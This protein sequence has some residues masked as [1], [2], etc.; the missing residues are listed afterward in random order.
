MV[1]QR[2]SLRAQ[3]VVQRPSTRNVM[4][5]DWRHLQEPFFARSRPT[6]GSSVV[7]VAHNRW[8]LDRCEYYPLLPLSDPTVRV[9]LYSPGKATFEWLSCLLFAETTWPL[10]TFASGVNWCSQN[11]HT[12]F[13]AAFGCHQRGI[14]YQIECRISR[15]SSQVAHYPATNRRFEV[16]CHTTSQVMPFGKRMRHGVGRGILFDLPHSPE[17]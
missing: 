8:S 12:A 5:T 4:R 13:F 17:R 2:R 15:R 3:E 9:A 7:P 6:Q 10:M 1:A 11:L 16:G 14:S